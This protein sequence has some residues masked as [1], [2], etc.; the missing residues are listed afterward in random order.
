MKITKFRIK[1]GNVEIEMEGEKPYIDKKFN[2]ITK[3]LVVLQPQ[4]LTAPPETKQ[5]K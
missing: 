3:K 4:I 2:E 5:K 1:I